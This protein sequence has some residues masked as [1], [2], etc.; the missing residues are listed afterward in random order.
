[1]RSSFFLLHDFLPLMLSKCIRDIKFPPPLF[2]CEQLIALDSYRLIA[3]FIV[4]SMESYERMYFY[5]FYF[6]VSRKTLYICRVFF[7]LEKKMSKLNLN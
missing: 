4:I 7:L 3:V 1:M 2:F 5:C 6:P